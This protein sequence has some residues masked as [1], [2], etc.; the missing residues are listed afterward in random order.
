MAMLLTGCPKIKLPRPA[1][2]GMV[3]RSIEVGD[4]KRHFWVH[5]PPDG[6]ESLPLIL[7][8]H[9]GGT[10]ALAF[11]KNSGLNKMADKEGY[12]VLYPEGTEVL[13]NRRLWHSEHCCDPVFNVNDVRFI[14]VLL[15]S[16]KE[17]LKID[18]NRIYAVG[19]SNGGMMVHKI[20]AELGDRLAAAAVIAG[21]V[22]GQWRGR[23][24]HNVT[25]EHPVASVPMLIMHGKRD[26]NVP[27]GGG[28]S[29]DQNRVDL[30]MSDSVDY[31]VETNQCKR[32][33]AKTS[34]DNEVRQVFACP[35]TGA[36][37]IAITLVEGGHEWFKAPSN[38]NEEIFSFF[39]RH[40]RE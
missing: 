29:T 3:Q 17:K 14:R 34:T 27:F 23:H 2:A 22:G 8:F 10:G 36:E 15:N 37:V 40:R 39:S 16:S 26:V 30:S 21:T 12:V 35:E 11:A 28:E 31:W 13:S 7:A 19:L 38:A 18:Q 9:A 1:P 4:T 5:V 24:E 20:A 32:K 33:A 6:G 25:P